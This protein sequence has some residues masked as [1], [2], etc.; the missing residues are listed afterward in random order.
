MDRDGHA[1]AAR[2]ESPNADAAV[3]AEGGRAKP[4]ASEG[5]AAAPPRCEVC[6]ARARGTA[7]AACFGSKSPPPA[8]VSADA[9][10]VASP[11]WCCCCA[12]GGRERAS[13]AYSQ[14]DKA[15]TMAITSTCVTPCLCWSSTTVFLV[16]EAYLTERCYAGGSG[17]PD[18]YADELRVAIRRRASAGPSKFSWVDALRGHAPSDHETVHDFLRRLLARHSVDSNRGEQ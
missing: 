5:P 10:E 8:A 18:T 2:P 7:W 4:R 14:S 12:A 3:R 11:G 9:A 15:P 6:S 13:F 17:Q 1:A 16:T